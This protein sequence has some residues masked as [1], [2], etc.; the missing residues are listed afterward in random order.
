MHCWCLG[1]MEAH[2]MMRYVVAM[3]KPSYE[4]N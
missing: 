1:R 4:L 2:E 3:A